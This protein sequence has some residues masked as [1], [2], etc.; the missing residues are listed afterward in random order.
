MTARTRSTL[1]PNNSRRRGGQPDDETPGKSQNRLSWK[2]TPLRLQ[3]AILASAA[4]VAVTF[5]AVQMGLVHNEP[6]PAFASGAWLLILA[7]L[8]P[9]LA[10]VCV[11][12][13]KAP[14]AAGIVTGA[15]LLAPG[16]ALVDAQFIHDALQASRPELMVPTSLAALTPATGAYLLLVGHLLTGA[17]G[18]LAAGRAGAG[19]DS[20][21][22]AALDTATSTT[23]R[24]RA[25]G[26]A[27][28]AGSVSV[29]GLLMP[30]FGSDNAFIVARDLIASPGLVKYGGLL[31]AL[32]LLIGGVAAAANSR[33]PVARGMVVGLFLAL[34]W[35]VV[36]QIVA[37]AAVD[38]LHMERGA[39]LIALVP[40]GLL[41]FA[42]GDR[43][44]DDQGDVQLEGS[45]ILTGVL[46]VLAGVATL[47]GAFTT[48]VVTS[49]D[50]PESYA[51]RQ[52]L[53]AGIVI[54]VLSVVLF[55]KWAS[56]VRP[57]F[58]VALGSVP[59]VGLAA[60]DTAFTATTVG[61]L[62]PGFPVVTASTHVGPAVWFTIAAFAVAAAAAIAAAVTGGAERDDDV[63]LSKP[64]LHTRYAIP[65]AGA[66]LFAIG[67]FT[68]PMIKAAGY[69]PAGIWSDFRLA[70]WGLLIGLIV[71]VGAAAIAAFARPRRAAALL[72]GAAVVAGV[73]LL[74]LPLTGGRVAGAGAGSGTWLTLA[75]LVALVAAGVAALTDPNK[76]AE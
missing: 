73:R 44:T 11:T 38:W 37:V 56:A 42:T 39:P 18:L 17:A 24:G 5:V 7:A 46:G 48:L 10:I 66:V 60:L 30:P 15:A 31:I 35:L 29:V 12:I 47:F 68:S 50:Q 26:W 49:V 53:P 43:E 62:I 63:D 33:I 21:Y 14:T 54:I 8:P 67:A 22:F 36:P 6:A 51:N 57:A 65:A 52:L 58:I 69:T 71:V 70:S 20:D 40:I 1:G 59:L 76:D 2:A 55:T 23:G 34:A 74:E 9:G 45:P 4:G 72:F 27:L 41:I 25:V 13:G 61:N 64:T 75:C 28:A 19:P 32:T 3:L 16:L